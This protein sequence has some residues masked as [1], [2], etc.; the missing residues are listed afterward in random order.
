[1]PEA[2]IE[3]IEKSASSE[4]QEEEEED[5]GSGSWFAFA[6]LEAL[7][8]QR[9]SLFELVMLTNSYYVTIFVYFDK[10]LRIPSHC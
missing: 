7:R 4:A 1:M 6:H 5:Q 3:V 9:R 10:I 2:V 8:A